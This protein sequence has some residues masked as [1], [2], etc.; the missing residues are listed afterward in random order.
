MHIRY[1]MK[2][3]SRFAR[4]DRLGLITVVVYIQVIIIRL[5]VEQAVEH[6]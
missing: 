3:I 5:K 6:I 4:N 2:K 1:T